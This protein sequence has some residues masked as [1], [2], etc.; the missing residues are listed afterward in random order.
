MIG[1]SAD[2]DYY[3]TTSDSHLPPRSGWKKTGEGRLPAPLVDGD[4]PYSEEERAQDALQHPM[5]TAVPSTSDYWDTNMTGENTTD[6]YHHHGYDDPPGFGDTTLYDDPHFNDLSSSD[7]SSPDEW[8]DEAMTN[9]ANL[10]LPPTTAPA[11]P[12]TPPNGNV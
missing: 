5:A 8:E 1:T 6:S 3:F 4:A 2:V 7:R 10:P 12:P 9:L 11:F